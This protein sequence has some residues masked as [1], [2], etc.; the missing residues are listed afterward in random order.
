MWINRGENEFNMEGYFTCAFP[1]LFDDLLVLY[2]GY[3][4]HELE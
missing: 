3:R 1:T 4:E 2:N